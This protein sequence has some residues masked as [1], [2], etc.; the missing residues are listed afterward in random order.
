MGD[1]GVAAD[2]GTG[3][4]A[5]AVTTGC[6]HTCVLL[7]DGTVKCFGYNN[8]GQ[9]GQVSFRAA[10]RGGLVTGEPT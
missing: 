5:T 1:L 3:V 8:Y 7:D 2:L 6:R 4:V 9:L 10:G